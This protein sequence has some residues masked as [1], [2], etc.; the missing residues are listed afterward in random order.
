MNPKLVF[1][2]RDM[3]IADLGEESCVPDLSGEI[4]LQNKLS[5]FLD[6]EDE[7]YEGYGRVASCYPY[8]QRNCYTRKL[9]RATVKTAILENDNLKAVFLPEYGGRLWELWDKKKNC[10]L[11]YTNDVIRFSNLAVKN[12]WFSGGVEWNIGIIGHTPFTTEQLYV[13]RTEDEY[14]NPILRMYE[15]ERIRNISYQMD[16]WLETDSSFLNCRMRVVNETSEVVPMYWWSNIAVPEYENGRVIVPAKKAYTHTNKIVHKVDI[17]VVNG[18]DVTDYKKIPFSVDYFFELDKQEPK[19]IA[20]VN[21]E[22]YG[23]LHYSTERLCSRKL[24]SWGNNSASDHWQDFL[25]E[26][27]GRYLEIQAGHGKTQYGC[28]PMAPNTT[29]EW[30]EHFGP[31]EHIYNGE[32][33]ITSIL[34]DS[35][36]VQNLEEKLKS[37]KKLALQ[38]A[39]LLESGSGYGILGQIG[40]RT[41][42]LEFIDTEG[43]YLNW[44]KFIDGGS[45][46][47]PDPSVKPDVFLNDKLSFSRLKTAVKEDC[48]NNWYAHYHLGIRYYTEGKNKKA[49][50]SF[51]KSLKLAENAWALHG[52]AC[53]KYR[54]GKFSQAIT[55]IE[56]GMFLQK[57]ELSYLKEG[58]KLL[59]LCEG[60]KELRDFY[61]Y[62]T[63][64]MQKN[65]RL[66]FY[67]IFAL[68]KLGKDKKAYKL[69]EENGGFVLDD[70]QEDEDS[71]ADLWRE[72]YRNLYGDPHE[73]PYRYHFKA[74]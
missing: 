65:S 36:A 3:K 13:A 49:E 54:K 22:G 57:S 51:K 33:Q 73:V 41:S 7:I 10:N 17:P 31:V 8:R 66:K 34:R 37:T 43:L 5:F 56:K 12:A 52:L 72:L 2:E 20:N 32:A 9:K 64:E 55:Y 58:F 16:F 14:G 30:M 53:I 45:L 6:E 69:L 18:I 40:K 25:T 59:K 48:C 29:W 60:Y 27:A 23:L 62:L 24:F 11:L 74:Y 44:K 4:V 42:H 46:P 39:E 61:R 35:S 38:K 70:I 1:E 15:Y 21:E 68:H 63:P 47:V 19:Y 67:Y 26:N 71:L 28:I 50:K